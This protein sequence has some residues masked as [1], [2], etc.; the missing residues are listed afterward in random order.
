LLAKVKPTTASFIGFFEVG[1]GCFFW[2][3]SAKKEAH[4]TRSAAPSSVLHAPLAIAMVEGL[5]RVQRF[6]GGE[7]TEG[8][9]ERARHRRGLA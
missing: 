6:S 7:N 4:S 8:P 1:W 5:R 3:S 2:K 9:R